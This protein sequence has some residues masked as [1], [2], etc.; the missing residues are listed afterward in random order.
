MPALTENNFA[1]YMI[2]LTIKTFIRRRQTH[3]NHDISTQ[4]LF[5]Q[6]SELSPSADDVTAISLALPN[7]QSLTDP[8]PIW[9]LKECATYLGGTVLVQSVQLFLAVSQVHSR[10]PTNYSTSVRDSRKQTWMPLTSNTTGQFQ[11]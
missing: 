10:L 9:L 4:A 8:V 7:K 5:S 3:Q 2:K 6:A 11:I 1:K